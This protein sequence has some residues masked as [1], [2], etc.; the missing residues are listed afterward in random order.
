MQI[1]LLNV[2]FGRCT[3]ETPVTLNVSN[4][5][6]NKDETI[7]QTKPFIASLNR[8]SGINWRQVNKRKGVKKPIHTI[9]TR[10]KQMSVLHIF[11]QPI[12]KRMYSIH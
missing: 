3:A 6:S 11:I 1:S 5:Y 9:S 8:S 2:I 10:Q 7:L 12:H 4:P